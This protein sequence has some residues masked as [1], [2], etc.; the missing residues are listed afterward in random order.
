MVKY[1]RL[2]EFELNEKCLNLNL[3]EKS[4]V[5]KKHFNPND[6]KSGKIIA[7]DREIIFE[8]NLLLCYYCYNILNI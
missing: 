3:N 8:V 1:F 7:K 6:I 4:C 5:C 2:Y